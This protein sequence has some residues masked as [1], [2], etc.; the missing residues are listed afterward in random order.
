MTEDLH[1]MDVRLVT[2]E[3][4]NKKLKRW[5]LGLAGGALGLSL[6]SMAGPICDVVTG[7]RLVIRD[8][9]GRQ[10]FMVDA[11][12]T[13]TPTV[14]FASRDG[15]VVGKLGVNDDGEGYLTLF[16]RKGAVKASYRMGVDGAD[17]AAPQTKPEA[18]KTD[19]TTMAGD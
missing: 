6:L 9:S 16:D 10:R 8:N 7:E 18:K 15:R 13:D 17:G 2:L 3:R 4:E 19:T 12:N 5:G 14:S 11:Y 1:E